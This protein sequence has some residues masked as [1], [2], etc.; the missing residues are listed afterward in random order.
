MLRLFATLV[1]TFA[2]SSAR[3]IGAEPVLGVDYTKF[4][5]P[6][7]LRGPKKIV[8]VHFFSY[9][10][11]LCAEYA[12]A[13]RA[14]FAKLPQDVHLMQ[15]PVPINN[16]RG[17]FPDLAT[18]VA[19]DRMKKTAALDPL[20]YDQI[21][22]GR[23]GFPDVPTMRAWLAKNGVAEAQLDA[24]M[25]SF[26]YAGPLQL[27]RKWIAAFAASSA[28]LIPQVVIDGRYRV[29]YAEYPGGRSAAEQERVFAK[30]LEVMN[31]LIERAREE[32]LSAVN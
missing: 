12:P 11:F 29:R 20:I 14:W 8:V 23:T 15:V 18:Y 3:A 17:S 24:E 16:E 6:A 5:A 31:T 30:R 1:L 32:R 9:Y 10:C 27:S 4:D 22:R 7:E 13:M 28:T 2:L 19:L 21:H 25:K 26:G